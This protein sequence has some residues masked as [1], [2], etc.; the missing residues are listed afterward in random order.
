MY[1][2]LESKHLGKDLGKDL[3]R[4]VAIPTCSSFLQQIHR[5]LGRKIGQGAFGEVF[6]ACTEN[7]CPTVI[8][9][10]L[11]STPNMEKVWQQEWNAFQSLSKSK[12]RKSLIPQFYHGQMCKEENKKYG[13]IEEER[14]DGDLK[15]LI[16]DPFYSTYMKDPAN[17]LRLLGRVIHLLLEAGIHNHINLD[18]KPEN[19]LYRRTSNPK[20]TPKIVMGDLGWVKPFTDWPNDE[21]LGDMA[22]T[23]LQTFPPVLSEEGFG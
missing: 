5:Q 8:K 7:K 21:E 1:N 9:K 22:A 15:Q 17:R 16:K 13:L 12:I 20:E 23:I 19:F 11:L 14:Y 10:S 18:A 2:L 4:S 3:E 6:E